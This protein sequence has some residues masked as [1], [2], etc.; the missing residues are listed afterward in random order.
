M[1]FCSKYA[2]EYPA[3]V[4]VSITWETFPTVEGS[5]ITVNVENAGTSQ[6]THLKFTGQ[7]VGGHSV[8]HHPL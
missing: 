1:S 8:L 3:K 7:N 4:A 6:G 5:G 2:L